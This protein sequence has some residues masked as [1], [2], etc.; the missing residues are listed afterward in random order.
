MA[1]CH[2]TLERV[3]RHMQ[4]MRDEDDIDE[5]YADFLQEGIPNGVIQ[6]IEN[7]TRGQH[8]NPRWHAMRKGLV[9]ASNI[10]KVVTAM[11]RPWIKP[12]KLKSDLLNGISSPMND[13]MEWGIDYEEDAL[14]EYVE[15]MDLDGFKLCRPGLFLYPNNPLV[16]ASPDGVIYEKGVPNAQPNMLVEVKCPYSSRFKDPEEAAVQDACEI[17]ANGNLCLKRNSKWYYQIQAQMGVVGVTRCDLVVFTLEGIEIITV[18][19][20][21]S[22]FNEMMNAVGKFT[23]EFL[24]PDLVEECQ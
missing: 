16:G 15:Q 3:R 22:F 24:Y 11:K 21:K 20:K 5:N 4:T 13:A 14:D 18:N 7:T 10:K 6:H 1:D 12:S 2:S 23:E 19:F 8:N 17:G 9:T